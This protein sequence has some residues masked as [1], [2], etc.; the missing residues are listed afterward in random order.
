MVK[1]N[2]LKTFNLA[3][4]TAKI[5]ILTGQ[6]VQ[7]IVEI[8]KAL[9]EVKENISYGDFQKWLETDI[10][11]SKRTAY[12]FMKV[13]QEFPDLQPVA[14]LGI[15]KLLALTDIETDD[16]KKIISDYDLE[17]MTVKEVEETVKDEKMVKEVNDFIERLS[18]KLSIRESSF[19]FAEHGFT[20][21][22]AQEIKQLGTEIDEAFEQDRI[23]QH[24]TLLEL[25][26]IFRDEKKFAKFVIQTGLKEAIEALVFKREFPDKLIA[27]WDNIEYNLKKGAENNG[28]NGKNV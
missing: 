5:N 7:N 2:K 26:D 13:A 8:G 20:D 27:V 4:K 19:D 12:N 22:E 21:E 9:L 10:N 3:E 14:N 18:H 16:R 15:R 6:T 28:N 11:Y 1:P 25:K 17:S 24:Q 23:N